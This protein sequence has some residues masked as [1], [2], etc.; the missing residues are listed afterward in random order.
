MTWF[1]AAGSLVS[2]T[3]RLREKLDKLSNL[4]LHLVLFPSKDL[5]LLLPCLPFDA[6]RLN[7]E[8]FSHLKLTDADD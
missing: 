1:F 6:S 4:S 5:D 2:E 7:C 3:D 8:F